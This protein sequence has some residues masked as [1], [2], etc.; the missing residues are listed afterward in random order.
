MKAPIFI[1]TSQ[2]LAFVN[3]DDEYYALANFA[4]A[5]VD[6]EML[7]TEAIILEFGNHLH[8]ARWK[9]VVAK[10]ITALRSDPAIEI[11]PVDGAL[12]ER[13]FNLYCTRM[14]KDWSLTDCVSFVVMQERGLVEALTAD[15]HFEQ[16]GFRAILRELKN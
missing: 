6:G 10:T 7:T 15:H 4:A 11:L 2:L 13:A 12:F 8:E 9:S 3:M 16:A 14:D 5:T 1:D